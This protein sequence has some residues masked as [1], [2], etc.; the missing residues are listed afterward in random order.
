MNFEILLQQVNTIFQ[1]YD[2]DNNLYLKSFEI[3]LIIANKS[4][5][6]FKSERHC[7]EVR[8]MDV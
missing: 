5:N 8:S 2:F 6:L 1:Q 3:C 4:E 7:S